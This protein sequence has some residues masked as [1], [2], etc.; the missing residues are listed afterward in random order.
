MGPLPVAE[1]SISADRAP[2][3]TNLL[4]DIKILQE[5]PEGAGLAAELPTR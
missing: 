4:R 1:V 5:N 3:Y 2:L